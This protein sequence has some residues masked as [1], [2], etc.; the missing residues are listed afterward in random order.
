MPYKTA[1]KILTLATL[2]TLAACCGMN[3]PGV[4]LLEPPADMMQSPQVTDFLTPI[5]NYL[6]LEPP[7][8]DK[9]AN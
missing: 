6:S 7:P 1:F 4:N 5:S 3:Q 8:S 9:P 2:I